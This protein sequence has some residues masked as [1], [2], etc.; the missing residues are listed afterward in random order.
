MAR[1]ATEHTS[2]LFII[3]IHQLAVR[4]LI[5][6]GDWSVIMD[7]TNFVQYKIGYNNQS[8][9]LSPYNAPIP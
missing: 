8:I 3:L 2:P 1:I 6:T 4:D 5:M 9:K 7:Q